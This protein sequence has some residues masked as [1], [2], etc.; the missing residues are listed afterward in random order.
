MEKDLN[1]LMKEVQYLERRVNS[2]EKKESRRAGYR[3]I[4]M[5]IKIIVVGLIIFGLWRGY[6]YI[7]NGIP[8]LIS[9][10]IRELIPF[11]KK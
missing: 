4:K 11:I 3:Y 8:D 2:L 10:K 1:E 5:I 6:D 7:V 9:D